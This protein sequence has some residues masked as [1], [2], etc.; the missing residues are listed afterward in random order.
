MY[1]SDEINESQELPKVGYIRVAT[2]AKF[3]GI[4]KTTIWR[5]SKDGTFPKPVRLTEKTTAWKAE[6]VHEWLASREA[7]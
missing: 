2:L 4:S 3:L 7:A 1:K 5:K 6:L